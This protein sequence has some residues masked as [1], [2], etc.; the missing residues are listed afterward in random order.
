M[1]L[2]GF[3]AHIRGFASIESVF[4]FSRAFESSLASKGEKQTLWV[5]LSISSADGP[6]RGS[7]LCGMHIKTPSTVGLNERGRKVEGVKI[8]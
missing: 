2:V 7:A 4:L 1:Y 5:L 3:G 8:L 6:M